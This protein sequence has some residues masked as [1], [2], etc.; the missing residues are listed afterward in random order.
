MQL[1]SL[2]AMPTLYYASRFICRW[3]INSPHLQRRIIKIFQAN[4]VLL[5]FVLPQSP[6]TKVVQS[7]KVALYSRFSSCLKLFASCNFVFTFI[8]C[9][10]GWLLLQPVMFVSNEHNPLLSFHYSTQ[11]NL[12]S[13]FFRTRTF[14]RRTWSS[15]FTVNRTMEGEHGKSNKQLTVGKSLVRSQV[16]SQFYLWGMFTQH[17]QYSSSSLLFHSGVLFLHMEI[18]ENDSTDVEPNSAWKHLWKFLKVQER[19]NHSAETF[20]IGWLL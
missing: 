1:W 13:G 10:C 6:L 8:F 9:L 7:V 3:S 2:I 18:C 17:P 16:M 14:S 4:I 11:K 5:K 20:V 19:S 15:V 12:L